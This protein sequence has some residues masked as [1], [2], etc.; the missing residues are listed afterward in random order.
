MFLVQTLFWGVQPVKECRMYSLIII[1]LVI[2]S[3]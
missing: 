2:L 1:W 3:Y